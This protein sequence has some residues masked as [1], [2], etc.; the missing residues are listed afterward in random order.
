[1]A[2]TLA[3]IIL[4]FILVGFL[5]FAGTLR[6]VIMGIGIIIGSFWVTGMAI[7][8]EFTKGKIT[9]ILILFGIGIFLVFGS[10]LVQQTVYGEN[11]Y[12][13]DWGHI[14]CN[15]GAYEP[16]YI[17]YL[18]DKPLYICNSYT[19]ECRLNVHPDRNLGL[20]NRVYLYQL[21]DIN[22]LNCGSK[23]KD[24]FGSYSKADEKIWYYLDY[25]QSIK[26]S[27]AFWNEKD[28]G[29]LVYEAD[30]RK[31]YIQG[32]ESGKVYVHKSCILNPA[33][34]A[35]VLAGGLNELSK[36]GTNRCQNYI[37]GYVLTATKTYSYDNKNVVCQS[38]NLYEIDTI[39]LLDGS[40]QK[41]QGERITDVECC[42]MEPNCDENT[43]EFK[44]VVI[45]ECDYSYQCANAGE[46]V[47]ETGTSYVQ[48]KCIDNKCVKSDAITV[49]C[50]NNAICVDKYDKPNMVCK[51]FKCETDDEWLGHCGDGKCESVL[52]ETATSC[53]EDCAFILECEWYESLIKTEEKEYKIWNYFGIGEPKVVAVTKCVLASWVYWAGA[54]V[55]ILIL[56]IF[57]IIIW[58]PKTKSKRKTRR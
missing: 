47:V 23:I 37:I 20:A 43:F 54:G 7:Q 49:E 42:P 5:L 41:I 14:C 57:A 28:L 32:E 46:P 36:T 48:Y 18:D 51:N 56:G 6:W 19:D 26:F 31:F 50:T 45:K 58:K 10:G 4:G 33:L 1:M 11:I 17:R 39:T 35:R 52:G 27:A 34:K 16:K 53:P 30:Y 24:G 8:G 40:T 55:I 3:I 22:G 2:I 9:F 21:C 12:K 15:E 13:A 25:G 38:R 44:E 29:Y